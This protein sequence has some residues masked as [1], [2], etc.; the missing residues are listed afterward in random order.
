[1]QCVII[2]D[3]PA[4]RDILQT[5]I[6]DT[7]GIEIAGICKDALEAKEFLRNNTVDVLF[8]DINMPRLSGISL[9]KTLEHPPKVILTTAYSEYA[10]EGYELNVVDYLL[11]PFSFE[12][13]LKAVD[14]AKQQ[15]ARSSHDEYITVKADGKLFRVSFEEILFAESKGDYITLHTSQN[16]ITFNQTLKDLCKMLPADLFCRVH[17]SYLVSLKRIE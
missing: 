8:L 4:S 1:M 13:F 5:Y 7:P 16:R 10:L 9:L 12:R 6:S 17:K 11:K 2:D 14:K 3:E 15:V